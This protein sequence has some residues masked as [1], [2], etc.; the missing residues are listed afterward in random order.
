[1]EFE[2]PETFK[3]Y[4]RACPLCNKHFVMKE[5]QGNLQVQIR[6][7]D[8]ELGTVK[9]TNKQLE[10]EIEKEKYF[11]KLTKEENRRLK[12]RIREC[13]TQIE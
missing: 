4:N 7:L 13:I 1:M 3:N 2:Y 9:A 6:I 12:K 10:F 11:G 8:G 5:N